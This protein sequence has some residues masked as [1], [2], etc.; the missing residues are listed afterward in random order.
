[1]GCH[2]Q[3]PRDKKARG[4][5]RLPDSPSKDSSA[6]SPES[7]GRR[8]LGSIYSIDSNP[9][10]CAC[11]AAWHL[12][13]APISVGRIGQFALPLPPS[14]ATVFR[15]GSFGC[16]LSSG[17]AR[18]ASC[19]GY[20]R[21]RGNPDQPLSAAADPLRPSAGGASPDVATSD[22]LCRPVGA[23]A[24]SPLPR[25]PLRLPSFVR[26]RCTPRRQDPR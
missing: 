24:R 7:P 23:T 25:S 3:R 6:C 16:D 18:E 21:M 11:G 9:S 22:T 4:R 5:Y 8:L 1:V 2:G 19:P 15:R 13:T 14:D 20:P 10:R 12:R 17:A 26:S